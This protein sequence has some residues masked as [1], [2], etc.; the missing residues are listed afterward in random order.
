MHFHSSSP[1]ASRSGRMFAG[2]LSVFAFGAT[3]LATAHA[4]P[5]TRYQEARQA[6]LSGQTYES[7]EVCLKEAAAAAGEAKKGNL[8]DTPDRYRQN[9][10]ARCN[11]LPQADRDACVQRVEGEG[12]MSGSVEGG[13]IYRETR[14]IVTEPSSTSTAPAGNSTMPAPPP[15]PSG[16]MP[17]RY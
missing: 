10:L 8:T 17:S 14:T 3:L 15:P 16:G 12:T 11:V 7:K 13:G 9:A 1:Q 6:C 5:N 4:A 2:A